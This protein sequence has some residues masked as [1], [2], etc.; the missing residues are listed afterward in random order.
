MPVIQYN[1]GGLWVKKSITYGL[2]RAYVSLFRLGKSLT[3]ILDYR[4][5]VYQAISING[6]SK[7][8]RPDIG[9][10]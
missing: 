8:F 3:Y 2:L 1:D 10:I 6:V 7:S 5:V 9:L 4:H